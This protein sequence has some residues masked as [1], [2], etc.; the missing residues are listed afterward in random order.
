MSLQCVVG[1]LVY[2]ATRHFHCK[3]RC[4]LMIFNC[5]KR[6]FATVVASLFTSQ[7]TEKTTKKSSKFGA[8]SRQKSVL[9]TTSIF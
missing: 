2:H 6:R 5:T 9:K 3:F 7:M 4:F 8:E 1:S